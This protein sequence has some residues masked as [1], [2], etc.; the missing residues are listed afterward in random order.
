MH[1]SDK[2]RTYV[3]ERVLTHTGNH[4]VAS[5]PDS[6]ITEAAVVLDLLSGDEAQEKHFIEK[7]IPLWTGK[8]AASYLQSLANEHLE[9]SEA[10]LAVQKSLDRFAASVRAQH[11]SRWGVWAKRVA[12][13]MALAWGVVLLSRWWRRHSAISVV[14]KRLEE[15]RH[16]AISVVRKRLGDKRYEMLLS[17][18]KNMRKRLAEEQKELKRYIVEPK[19][20]GNT[21]QRTAHAI[22]QVGLLH[23][24]EY[25]CRYEAA[26]RGINCDT[27]RKYAKG[28]EGKLPEGFSLIGLL[29]RGILI[30]GNRKDGILI[31]VP[32]P[33]CA[34]TLQQKFKDSNT[35]G[36]NHSL[37]RHVRRVT[38][39]QDL[40][41]KHRHSQIEGV[42]SFLAMRPRQSWE[43][44]SINDRTAVVLEEYLSE[45]A[46]KKGMT[47]LSEHSSFCPIDMANEAQQDAIIDFCISA[48]A[49]DTHDFNIAIKGNTIILFDTERPQAKKLSGIEV[50]KS[51]LRFRE[52]WWRPAHYV[53]NYFKENEM[54]GKSDA[55]FIG[56]AIRRLFLFCGLEDEEVKKELKKTFLE[57]AEH[58]K[59]RKLMGPLSEDDLWNCLFWCDFKPSD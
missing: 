9:M 41:C 24:R 44:K 28:I 38:R 2:A 58:L 20:D 8:V 52:E 21:F 53:I 4:V 47:P 7:H 11:G 10:A 30:F 48:G 46:I 54:K 55:V 12:I 5:L 3:N 37:R 14:R 6:I 31:K 13:G 32:N 43:E 1:A 36:E 26:R 56:A 39:A 42:R 49:E 50:A 45:E 57:M 34:Y 27:I 25:Q 19:E 17:V 59:K 33:Y 40:T 51:L 35:R 29:D 23:P 22:E 16:S 15:R 18:L